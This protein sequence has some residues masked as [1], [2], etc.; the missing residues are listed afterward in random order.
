MNYLSWKRAT[1]TKNKH[2]LA[3]AHPAKKVTFA[4]K[5]QTD[6]KMGYKSRKRHKSRR[7]RFQDVLRNTRVVFLFIF[8]ALLLYAFMNRRETWAW[9]KTYWYG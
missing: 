2:C 6:L 3:A 1:G 5:Q 8:L 4:E 9:L 7:E